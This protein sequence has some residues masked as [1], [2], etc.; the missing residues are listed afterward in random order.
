MELV[1]AC[2]HTSHYLSYV[3]IIKEK[4]NRRKIIQYGR[5]MEML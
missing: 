2:H 1:E 4:S 3:N 5:E